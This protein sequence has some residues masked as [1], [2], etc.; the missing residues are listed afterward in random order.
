MLLRIHPDENYRGVQ[1]LRDEQMKLHDSRG[2]SGNG[3][4]NVPATNGTPV[5]NNPEVGPSENGPGLDGGL[6][7]RAHPIPLLADFEFCFRLGQEKV[8]T[9]GGTVGHIAPGKYIFRHYSL[10]ST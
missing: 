4:Q 3:V 8:R 2:T 6:N 10:S 1:A 9:K 7:D 5:P